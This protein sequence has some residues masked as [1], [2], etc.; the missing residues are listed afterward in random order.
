[1]FWQ[2]RDEEKIRRL[3]V[4]RCTHFQVLHL[5]WVLHSLYGNNIMIIWNLAG[6][7]LLLG[8]GMLYI[9]LL[10][11]SYFDDTDHT[12]FVFLLHWWLVVVIVA[13]WVALRHSFK[14]GEGMW[15]KNVKNCFFYKEIHFFRRTVFI[16]IT[17]VIST[18]LMNIFNFLWNEV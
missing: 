1:M 13:L 2:R 4:L 14:R 9:G 3:N 10:E 16:M 12:F 6:S 8:D 18:Y 15:R 7:H 5:I 17:T 11:I